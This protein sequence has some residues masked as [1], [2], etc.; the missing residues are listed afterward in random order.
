MVLDF[1]ITIL[2]RLII[3]TLALTSAWVFIGL[4]LTDRQFITF[5]KI[6]VIH[7]TLFLKAHIIFV[8]T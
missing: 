1:E 5:H 6:S 8:R 3:L 4:L 7:N 2:L